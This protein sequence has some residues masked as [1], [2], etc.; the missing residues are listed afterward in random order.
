MSRKQVWID[1]DCGV[2]DAIALFSAFQ[3][4]NIDILGISAVC[5]NVEE[6]KTYKNARDIA[7]LAKR[8]DIKVYHGA[9]KP[10]IVEL[11]MAKH[12]H[13]ENGVGDIVL[14]E[15]P[16][17]HQSEMGWDALYQAAK[18]SPNGISLVT[19]G[20]LTNIAIAIAKYPDLSQYINEILIMGGAIEGGNSTPSA[21]FNIFVDPHSAQA[22][23][24]SDIPKVMFGLDVTLKSSLHMDDILEIKSCN[25][26]VT[27]FFFESIQ[28][29]LIFYDKYGYKNMMCLHDVCPVLYLEYP[30][31]F[32]GSMAGVY[33]E[34]QGPLT[35]GKTVCDLKSD[36][37]F[38]KRDTLVMTEV[39]QKE[40][41]KIIKE[42]LMSY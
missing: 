28:T 9:T 25:N 6:E 17:V 8:D 40:F 4:K 38:E 15:S 13:G 32:S 11:E 29:C 42:L 20:P 34:T 18:N 12:V 37:K 22:V 35:F 2:D 21:E 41:A 31:L 33:V 10:M 7:H 27:D 1:S 3:L 24:M 5:G 19:L 36:F 39:N 16:S 23:F 26:E 30:D 14:E